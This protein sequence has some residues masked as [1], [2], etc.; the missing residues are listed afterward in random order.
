LSQRAQPGT[1]VRA[2][3]VRSS[4][5]RMHRLAQAGLTGMRA[6]EFE[7]RGSKRVGKVKSH[8]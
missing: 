5:D 4:I 1:R 3:Q 2:K 7:I 8:V 6:R